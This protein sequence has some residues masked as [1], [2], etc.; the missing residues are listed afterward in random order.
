[1]GG[2]WK[3]TQIVKLVTRNDGE[4]VK[5]LFPFFVCWSHT[6]KLLG[7]KHHILTAGLV[8]MQLPVR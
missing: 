3:E 8:H 1:M 2:R 7:K 6:V 5:I 4:V